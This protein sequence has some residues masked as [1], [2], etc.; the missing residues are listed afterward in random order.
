MFEVEW[1]RR[2]SGSWLIWQESEEFC[3]NFCWEAERRSAAQRSLAR[4][5]AHT[6]SDEYA[7]TKS[8]VA[9]LALIIHLCSGWLDDVTLQREQ[10][11]VSERGGKQR[12]CPRHSEGEQTPFVCFF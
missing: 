1:L 4:T 2:V 12:C 7:V 9:Y 11:T 8:P 6:S 10:I 5:Q 3:R